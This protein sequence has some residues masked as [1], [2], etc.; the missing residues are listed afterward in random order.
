MKRS[1]L[2]SASLLLITL[3]PSTVLAVDASSAA[4]RFENI[5]QKR[6]IAQTLRTQKEAALKTRLGQFKDQKRVAIA[7]K[8]DQNLDTVNRNRTAAMEKNLDK[9]TMILD[10]LQLRMETASSSGKNTSS[11]DAAIRVARAAVT[12][13]QTS[14]SVQAGKEYT[15]T[16]TSEASL[17]SDVKAARDRLFNDLKTVHTQIESARKSVISAYQTLA[18]ILNNG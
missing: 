6:Q 16:A 4:Q 17:K 7:T 1:L 5:T 11:I 10:K 15:V 2:V 13:T 18:S 9:M 14:V 12:D 3:L 8:V